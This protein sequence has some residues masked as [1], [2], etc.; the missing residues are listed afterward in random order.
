MCYLVSGRLVCGHVT[1]QLSAVAEG[2][3]AQRAG[4]ALLV[5]LVA[6]LDVFLQRRQALV[7]AVAVRTREQLGEVVRRARR[8]VCRSEVGR[9]RGR[10]FLKSP[11]NLTSRTSSQES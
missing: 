11:T 2:F 4:E 7:A 1:I 9:G 10:A 8:Q 3:G 6:I 5:P